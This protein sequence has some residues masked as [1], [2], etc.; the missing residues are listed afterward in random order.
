M[1]CGGRFFGTTGHKVRVGP[2]GPIPLKK[3]KRIKGELIVVP[4]T[5]DRPRSKRSMTSTPKT[6]SSPKQSY[7]VQPEFK[8]NILSPITTIK[9]HD[10]NNQQMDSNDDT[11]SLS[12][13]PSFADTMNKTIEARH[14]EEAKFDSIMGHEVQDLLPKDQEEINENGAALFN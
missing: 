6:N 11:P 7:V 10:K 14:R 4:D 13:S 9:E 1:G 2:F 5:P 12:N 3:V 8:R